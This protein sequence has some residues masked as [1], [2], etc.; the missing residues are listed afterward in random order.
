MS[1]VSIEVTRNRD[2]KITATPAP[3]Q[4]E[5][6]VK[7]RTSQ[8]MRDFQRASELRNKPYREFNNRSLLEY[9]DHCQKAW[10]SY[11]PEKSSDPDVA[12]QSNVVR[13]LTRNR[14]ISIAAHMT[15]SVLHPKVLAQND[16]DD[17]D[18]DAAQ[19]MRDLMEWRGEQANYVETFTY[20]VIAALVNPA[21]IIHTEFRKIPRVVKEI[22]D[23]GSWEEKEIEDEE[24]SGFQDQIVP[25]EELFIADFYTGDIQ[26]QPYLVWRRYLD[27]NEAYGKYGHNDNFKHVQPGTQFVFDKDTDTFYEQYDDDLE[28]S[29]VEEVVYY[30]RTADLEIVFVNGI[31]MTDPDRPNMRKDKKYPFAKGGFEPIDEGR[32]IYYK[33]AA[34]KM[35]GDQDV[36][37]ELYRILI[38]SGKL[39]S[40]PPTAVFGG[41]EVDSSVVMPGAVTTFSNADAKIEPINPSGNLNNTLSILQK[42]EA[43]AEES[44]NSSLLS[45][46]APKSASTAFEIARL[47]QNARTVM[48]LFGKMIGFL[49]RDLGDLVKNDI[50]Q[51]MT[52]AEASDIMGPTDR[53][54]FRSFLVPDRFSSGKTKSRKIVLDAETGMKDE[55]EESFEILQEEGLESD[56]EIWKINPTMFRSLKFQVRIDPDFRPPTNDALNRALNLEAYDRAIQNPA[57][58]QVEIYKELLLGSYENL[59]DDPDRFV[60]EQ[61]QTQAAEKA[62]RTSDLIKE[63]TGGKLGLNQLEG[64]SGR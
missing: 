38:D 59:R 27:Y 57:A 19:V 56:K 26:K 1:I 16:E 61:A 14:I 40:M 20:G 43:S 47:E 36:A 33:S 42:V 55:L 37:D 18:K 54:K 5:E 13:P 4:P 2:G 49:V 24:L 31:L 50:L 15:A 44:S 9:Q 34:D 3:F 64:L 23:D 52:V 21:V 58:N 60:N 8:V 35:K 45:G 6:K 10:N 22:M 41:E 7:E 48:G 32:F 17:E 63:I 51:Y 30:N 12:W 39:Q 53:L 46:Q 29:F 11:M 28:D 62:P 25:L